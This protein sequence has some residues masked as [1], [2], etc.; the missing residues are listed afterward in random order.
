MIR[1]KIFFFLIVTLRFQTL[2]NSGYL[3]SDLRKKI[4]FLILSSPSC[5]MF[6]KRSGLIAYG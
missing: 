1:F 3:S 6:L 5:D 2:S 4:R